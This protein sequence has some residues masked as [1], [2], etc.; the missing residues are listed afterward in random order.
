MQTQYDLVIIGGGA[1]GLM[2]AIAAAEKQQKILLVEKMEQAGRKL[3][4]T[5]K[6]RC[7]L[8]NTSPIKEF[9]SHIG[10]D[11]RFMRNA[12]SL[13]F[14][15]ELMQFFEEKGVE[16]NIERGSRV[17]PKSSKA[18]DIFLALINTIERNKNIT[19]LKNTSATDLIVSPNGI[20]GV[21]I[22]NGKNIDIAAPK[23]I[24]A[25]GGRSYPL[26]GSTGDGYSLAKNV[27]HTIVD[28]IPSLVPLV[29]QE[30]IPDELVGFTLKN[31]SLTISDAND[32]K[33]CNFF[34]EMTFTDNG[35]GGPIVLSASRIISRRLQAGE[36]LRATL[37]LKPALEHEVLDKKLIRELDENGSRILKDA[38]RLWLPAEMIPLALQTMTIEHYKRLNQVSANDRKKIMRMLKAMP[39]TIVGTRGFDEAIVTQGGVSL[40]EVN[41]KTMESKLV[42][43][44]YITGE[45]LDLDADTGGYNLQIAFSTG[46][47]AGKA[48]NMQ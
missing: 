27:G 24:L 3:R 22:N 9:I 37:D 12:F 6:G 16:L 14:N 10:S 20:A 33:I 48:V 7:N 45:L 11:G 34:G 32:K 39:F 21:T 29:C 13:F 40:K 47:A 8:T 1:S 38:L 43:N 31:V 41:P 2:A 17:F 42:K 18:L 5:G 30:A 25:T 23:V 4:I 46:Y 15:N 26:T 35:I 44:L 19:I 36:Q 28:P